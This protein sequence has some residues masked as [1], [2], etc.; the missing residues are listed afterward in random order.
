L[1]DF[2]RAAQDF[3]DIE[4]PLYYLALASDASKKE[5]P[6][7]RELVETYSN[8][9]PDQFWPLYFLGHAAFQIARTSQ[10]PSDLQHAESL[11]KKSIEL[12][13]GYADAHLD[14]G[15]VYFQ[16]HLWKEA[17]QEYEEAVSQQPDLIEAH[18]KL[19]RAYLQVGDSAHA[20]REKNTRER[21]QQQETE[22][23]ARQRQ[24]SVFLYN[25]QK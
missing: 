8:R 5:L 19:Y 11:L 20:Q 16:Q 2:L 14:L 6:E 22:Q 25:L 17:I 1:Q 23:D 18:F 15:N 10:L 21:L 13:P 3:P 7:T 9:H 24:V 12:H 4:M